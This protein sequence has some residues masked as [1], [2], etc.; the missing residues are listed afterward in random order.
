M[1]IVKK[2]SQGW[3]IVSEHTGIPI[4]SRVFASRSAARTFAQ[5]FSPGMY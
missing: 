2:I 1:A 4:V 3:I 5:K